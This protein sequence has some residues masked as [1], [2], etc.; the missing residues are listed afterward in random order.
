[1]SHVISSNP[2]AMRLLMA[3]PEKINWSLLS[4]THPD[5]V[6]LLRQPERIN[7]GRLSSNPS[8]K[9][10]LLNNQDKICWFN[11]SKKSQ[12]GGFSQR[13]RGVDKLEHALA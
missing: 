13:T 11:V 10:L 3:Y 9:W 2:A 12:H 5:A 4:T 7:W 8:A 6:K 1:M